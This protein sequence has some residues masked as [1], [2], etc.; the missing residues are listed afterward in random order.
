MELHNAQKQIVQDNHR[1][2]V[3]NCGRRFGKTTLSV[4][5]I[6]GR[7]CLMKKQNIAYIAPTYQ[8]ARDIAWAEFRRIMPEDSSAKPKYNEGRL[9]INI[10][11]GS[12]IWLKGWEN[13]ETLR[14][15]KFDFLI[16][17]EVAMMRN[18]W[19]NWQEVI[20]PTLTDTKGQAMFISTPKGFNHFY[21]LYNLQD[22]DSDY[23]SFHFTTYD[24]PFIPK[25]EIEKARKELTEDRFHQEYMADFR[26]TEG[27]VY[28][29]FNRD[30]HLFDEV[31]FEGQ[32]FQVVKTFGGH[33]FGTHN[34]CASITI[35][36][37]SDNIYWVTD[38]WYKTG[39]TDSEQA[40]Y[41]AA[42]KWNECYPDPESASGIEEMKRRG[43]NVRD[44]I[45]N[46]D[47][48]KNGINAVRELFKQRR[49]F[50]SNSCVN[51]IW[52]LETY[53]YP[54]KKTDKNEEE[55]PI[56]ENDHACLVG[57]T[58][59]K[60]ASG[61]SRKIKNVLIGNWVNT[62]KGNCMVIDRGLTQKDAEI[63]EIELSNGYKLKGTGNHKIFTNRGHIAID[64]LRDDDIIKV[65]N[66]NLIP[67]WKRQLSSMERDIIGM[68][69]TI[70][71]LADIKMDQKGFIKQFGNITKE[72]FQKDSISII[73]TEIERTTRLI[74]L[75]LYQLK[76]IYQTIIK[77]IGRNKNLEKRLE[78]I[79][80]LSE[81]VRKFG[82]QQIR[83]LSGTKNTEKNL[84]KIDKHLKRFARFA[85][86]DMKLIIHQEADFAI[87]I[88][89]RKLCG[90]EDVYN[91]TVKD[92]HC[93]YANGILVK[94]CDALRY[95]L[96]MESATNSKPKVHIYRPDIKK[97]ERNY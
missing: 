84:G 87:R 49:L 3:I 36:K 68:V 91:I 85:E 26:K 43:I 37:D 54:E 77:E 35:K 6:V 82:I 44:V 9:E 76:S 62:P 47:S 60:M 31:G 30:K 56:K 40:D 32:K 11:N 64:S 38:E 74:I 1:F 51:L 71:Q 5:E 78:K 70:A 66:T 13:I 69:N 94:N 29:E 18:F 79:L 92:E 89:K 52:E 93:Y 97:Y 73:K 88:V 42:L 63:Y 23:K 20:R 8:Q 72:Q 55:N 39:K 34:P 83:V 28:K 58:L 59:I 2:R 48:I 41:V 4:L 46:K 27:L 21:D 86:K 90:K 19:E 14:G 24:N 22:K 25:D 15:Q 57:D 33:D 67:V 12:K 45:K 95:A 96:S 17:D 10:I 80:T 16:I 7:A 65:L 61:E 53:S 81:T 50:I 75:N